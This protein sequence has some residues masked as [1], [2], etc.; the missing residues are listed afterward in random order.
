MPE[1]LGQGPVVPLQCNWA[2]H[3]SSRRL[4]LCELGHEL[5]LWTRPSLLMAG[6]ALSFSLS[7][8]EVGPSTHLLP[9]LLCFV[10]RQTVTLA[11]PLIPSPSHLPPLDLGVVDQTE[12]FKTLREA[13][14]NT[15][16]TGLGKV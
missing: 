3:D 14:G 4:R 11:F 16:Y 5:G 7:P 2:I 9:V 8:L 13:S 12:S 10:D 15:I 1:R 6:F